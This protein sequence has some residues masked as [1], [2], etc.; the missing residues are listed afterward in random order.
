MPSA[1]PTSPLA[2]KRRLEPTSMT[3][4]PSAVASPARNS[5]LGR[6]RQNSHSASVTNNDARLASSVAFATVVSR[7]ELCQKP[8]SPAKAKPAA[9]SSGQALARVPCRSRGLAITRIQSTGTASATR[10]NAL[11]VTPVSETR[12]QI[13]DSAMQSAPASSAA[14]GALLRFPAARLIVCANYKPRRDAAR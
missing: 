6:S 10:Q 4:P 13:G 3:T 12:T 9:I 7:I 1:S 11:A 2:E 5:A 8:R 14:S